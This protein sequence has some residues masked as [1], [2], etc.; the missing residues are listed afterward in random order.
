[1]IGF[2]AGLQKAE[3]KSLCVTIDPTT[4]SWNFKHFT[5]AVKREVE[6]ERERALKEFM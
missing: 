5:R 3:F 4:W 6:R 1:M 2:V